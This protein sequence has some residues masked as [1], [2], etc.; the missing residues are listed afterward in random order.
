MDNF[1]TG[2]ICACVHQSTRGNPGEGDTTNTTV[3]TL[4]SRPL[5]PAQHV[6]Y[7]KHQGVVAAGQLLQLCVSQPLTTVVLQPYSV[8]VQYPV[9][10]PPFPTNQPMPVAVPNGFFGNFH[11]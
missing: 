6:Q 5:P 2:F 11:K 8:S 10:Q 9:M 7:L 4:F 1:A 3:R